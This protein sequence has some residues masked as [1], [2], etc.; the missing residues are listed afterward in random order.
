[1]TKSRIVRF[2][3]CSWLPAGVLCV[4]ALAGFAQAQTFN[5]QSDWATTYPTSTAVQSSHSATWGA[6]G[7]GVPAA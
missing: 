1:M 5:V 2:A 4:F 3:A 7:T 6:G